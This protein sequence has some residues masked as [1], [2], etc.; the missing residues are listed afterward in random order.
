MAYE[1]PG[2]KLGTLPANVDLSGMIGGSGVIDYQFTAVDIAAAGAGVTGGEDAALVPASAATPVIG[3]LQNR[4]KKNEAG[5]V[6]VSG[7]SMARAGGTV[8]VGAYV[9]SDGSGKLVTSNK[10][11]SCGRAL[12]SAVVNDIFTVLLDCPA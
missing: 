9:K 6:I 3:I 1:I 10:A 12:Q 5:T 7:V 4:P 11:D 8:A 2:F